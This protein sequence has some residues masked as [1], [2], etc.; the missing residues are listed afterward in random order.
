MTVGQTLSCIKWENY[1]HVYN[2]NGKSLRKSVHS[3]SRIASDMR[4]E[5]FLRL[6]LMGAA[7]TKV[8]T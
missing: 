3:F 8:D 6:H 4:A 7:A 2:S 5:D 1:V